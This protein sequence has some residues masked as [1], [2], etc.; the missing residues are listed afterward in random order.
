MPTLRELV[1]NHMVSSMLYKIQELCTA[2]RIEY[3]YC[4]VY[5]SI[6]IGNTDENGQQFSP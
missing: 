3:F 2:K 1:K 4:I 6:I 5:Y